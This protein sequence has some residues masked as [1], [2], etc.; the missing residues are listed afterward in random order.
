MLRIS[1][2]SSFT[3]STLRLFSMALFS[4]SIIFSTMP[5]DS[6]RETANKIQNINSIV[7]SAVGE[8][9]ANA[10]E[11]MRYISVQPL[12]NILHHAGRLVFIFNRGFFHLL[13]ALPHLGSET[14][15]PDYDSHAVEGRHYREEA[16]R[17]SGAVD[18]C[19]RL[20][21]LRS[22][23][24]SRSP[25]Q[26]KLPLLLSPERS[27]HPPSRPDSH[28][29]HSAN[30]G[31]YF[32]ANL[33]N[34]TI[35]T[36]YIKSGAKIRSALRSILSEKR[37][38]KLVNRRKFPRLLPVKRQINHLD[39]FAPAISA[40]AA[41]LPEDGAAVENPG[42]MEDEETAPETG[43]GEASPAPENPFAICRPSAGSSPRKD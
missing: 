3:L 23:H 37:V 10:N 41:A 32:D 30:F 20:H 11:I 2:V 39:A 38:V 22:A 42:G 28:R 29:Q 6:S 33:Y 5:A 34:Y 19:H 21:P 27:L 18:D 36:D 40:S 43:E 13:G 14:V 26:A 31:G 15:L 9:S 35:V 7:I 24:H 16:D 25:R 12:H 8:L 4:R 17:V 1:F